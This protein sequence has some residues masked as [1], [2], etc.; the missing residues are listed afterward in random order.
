MTTMI[1][2][3]DTPAEFTCSAGARAATGV[4]DLVSANFIDCVD[5]V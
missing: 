3:F 2:T 4:A 5:L 1:Y